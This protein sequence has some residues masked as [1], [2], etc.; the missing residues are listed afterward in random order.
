MK[1]AHIVNVLEIS[2]VNRSSYLH[3]AQPITIQSMVDAKTK[4]QDCEVEL[5]AIKNK[6][7]NIKLP[8]EFNFTN[9]LER[10]CCDISDSLPKE[11]SLPLIG[12]ILS[13][14]FN[15]SDAEYFVYTNID[16]GLLPD[17]YNFI[18]REIKSGV[19]ALCINRRDMPKHINGKKIDINNFKILFSKKGKY[20]PGADCFM[21]KRESF[22][23]M[24]LGNVFIGVPPIGTVLLNEI[25][26]ASNNFR[27]I[28]RKDRVE[29][30]RNGNKTFEQLL[31]FH[32][33]SDRNW[34]QKNNPYWAEN[35]IQTRSRL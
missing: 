3:I 13:N 25:K 24:N 20:H 34:Q 6:Y 2:E 7:D 11:K 18:N 23:K 14:L 19:E 26:K 12:D 30:R 33:G 22:M 10:C 35:I 17:F 8:P 1:I 5:F 16:I 29:N 27:W 31:T 28:N 4:T 15:A 21:F 9:D 32:I